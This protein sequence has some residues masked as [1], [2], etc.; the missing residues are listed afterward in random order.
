MLVDIPSDLFRVG[1]KLRVLHLSNNQIT[2]LPSSIRHLTLVEDIRLANNELEELPEEIGSCTKLV[3]LDL[4]HNNLKSLPASI[5]MLTSMSRLNVSHN[6]IADRLPKTL[7]NCVELRELLASNNPRLRHVLDTFQFVT[8]LEWLDVSCCAIE[9]LDSSIGTLGSMQVCKLNDNQMSAVTPALGQLD[10]NGT[11]IR[12]DLNGNDIDTVPSSIMRMIFNSKKINETAVPVAQ[13]IV[14]GLLLG[15]INAARNRKYLDKV[16]VTHVLNLAGS[17]NDKLNERGL[18]EIDANRLF[19]EDF[20]YLDVDVGD[21][22]TGVLLP[23]FDRCNL[24]INR[25]LSQRGVV[26]CHCWRG[27]SRSAAICIAYLMA[28]NKI[29]YEVA[30]G[31]VESKRNCIRCNSAFVKQLKEYEKILEARQRRN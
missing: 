21:T 26:L 3:R 22:R 23:Y 11:M 30:S 10:R 4:N 29:S 14:P 6:D 7:E 1:S 31:L 24:F 25:A 16:G 15:G 17:G 2:K 13:E 19:P 27:V 18:K 12:M 5:G 20:C 8:K 28:K 9:S